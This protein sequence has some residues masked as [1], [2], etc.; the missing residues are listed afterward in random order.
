MN[1]KCILVITDGIGYN[2]SSDF[3]AFAAAKKPTYD[4]LF[5][6]VPMNYIKT[7]GLAV[8]LPDGQMGNSEVG[9]MTIGSGRVLYQN[10]VKIDKAIEDGSLAKNEVLLNL[11]KK[12][13]RVHI[14]GLYSD[15]GVHSHLKH[16]D[17]ICKICEQKGLQTYAH[18]ITDGRDVSPTS[19]LNFIKSLES[20]FKIA[21]ISGRFY[22]MDRDK[23]WERVNKAYQA[24][25]QNSNLQNI[26]ATQY[27][28][29]SYD[30]KIFDEFIE[31]ASFS[32]FGGIKPEDGIVFINFRNDRAREICSALSIKDFSEFQRNNI[33]ENLITMTNY[34]DKFNFPIMFKN[35]EIKD[36]LAEVIARNNLRQLHTAET[37]KYAHVTFFFNGGKEELVENE[38]RVLIPSPKVKTYDEKPQMSA[39]EVTQAVIKAIND[40]VDFIV[41]NYANGDMVGHTGDFD[42]AVKAVEAVDE[43][44]GS[45]IKVAKKEGYSY[46]QIS[47]HGNCEAM[48]DKKGGVLTNH[49]IFDVFAFVLADGVD[50]VNPGGLSNVAP[51]IL[52]LM[53]IDIPKIMDKPL[54]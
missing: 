3:N 32:D 31:P 19:G 25:S 18:A 46:M 6:N 10:L 13:K 53:D 20:K 48:Q 7:S 14:I 21:S 38:I 47:D 40:G 39:Y 35:D 29:N 44:L 54:I 1:K 8:G 11:I 16:F 17:E 24:I 41:V 30:N 49:T 5:K 26:T 51:T 50:K 36:T 27:M 22:A 23:R 2:E 37:E 52:K 43:C 34:D 42:A 28:Q 12:V 9:H 33:C 15:G 4:W 45:V